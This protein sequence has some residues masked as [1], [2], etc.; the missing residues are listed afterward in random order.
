MKLNTLY[1]AVLVGMSAS[2]PVLAHAHTDHHSETESSTL[3]IVTVQSKEQDTFSRELDAEYFSR[4]QAKDLH[5]MFKLEPSVQ[6]G[7]GSRNGQKIILRGVEDLLLNVQI[8][9]ARQ[10]ANLFHHQGRVQIDPYLLK[11]AR[12]ITGPAPADA[13][14]GAL[15]GSVQFETVDAQDLL[16]PGQTI[17]ARIGAHYESA[18][19]LR[20]GLVSA[21]GQLGDQGGLLAYARRNSNDEMRVGGGNKQPSTD[22]SYE[23]YLV[24]ASFL[25]VDGHSLRVS[26]QRTENIGGPLR[27]NAPWETNNP[28]QS[29]DDQ[30][31]YEQRQTLGYRYQSP[32]N[33]HLDLEFDLY[34]SDNGLTFTLAH[35]N[36]F[37]KHSVMG[38]GCKT[39]VALPQ[40]ICRMR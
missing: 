22:G 33:A 23:N 34:Q 27:A 32:H 30:L 17:G 35:L 9:G 25:D 10:G 2:A 39:P 6:V 7:T 12:V 20:G 19:N 28:V 29:A 24:K 4:T 1:Y 21:Y 8:D 31:I 13:G 26:A 37:L 5:D 40:P 11:R 38:I 15:G 14:S 18:S 36:P 3:P 16:A